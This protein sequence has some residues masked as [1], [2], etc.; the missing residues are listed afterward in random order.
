MKKQRPSGVFPVDIEYELKQSYLDYAMS[1]IIGRALPDVRDGLKPVHR[2]ILFAMK[3]LGN[4]SDKAYKKSARIV[5]DVIGK[6]HPHGD[7]AVYDAIVRMAQEFSLRYMLIDGQGNFGSVDGDSPAAMRYTEIRMSRIAH[8]LMSDVD[9]ETVD[10]STNYDETEL[11]PN[12]L[13]ARIPNLL[14]NGSSGIAVGMATNIPPHNLAEVVDGTIALIE[15]PNLDIEDLMKYIPGPDFPTGAYIDSSSNITEAYKTGRGKINVFARTKVEADKK[16]GREQ[17]I[18]TEIP[19]Q[20]NKARLIERIAELARDKKVR[21]I[22]ELRDESDKDGMRIVVDIKRGESSEVLLNNLYVQTQMHGSFGVNMVALVNNQPKLLNLKEIIERFISHRRSVVIR[23]TAFELRKAKEQAHILEGL[24]IALSN[25]DLILD[26]IQSSETSSKARETLLSYTWIKG[27]SLKQITEEVDQDL[28]RINRSNEKDYSLSKSQVNAI[29]ELRL[30]YLTR[31]EQNKIIE[32]FKSLILIIKNLVSILK[33]NKRLLEVVCTELQEVKEKFGDDRR[34]KIIS[35][36]LKLDH[37]DLINLEVKVVTLSYDGYVKSQPLTD[38]N[39]QRRGGRGKS[40]AQ[41]KAED[42][43]YKLQIASTHDTM[44]CFSSSGKIY[45]IKVYEFPQAGRTAKGKPINNL[46]PL[47]KG[48]RVTAMLAISKYDQGCN[49]FM[50]TKHAKVKKVDLT[51]FSRPRKGGICA[52]NLNE[53][54]ELLHVHLTNESQEIMMF[55]DAGKAIRFNESDVRVM[56]RTAR[57]VQGMRIEKNQRI[58]DVIVTE[59]D[60][61]IVLT[62]TE[63]GYGKRT[64]VSAYRKTARCS[65]GVISISTSDRNGLVV[66]AGLVKEN[67]D[68]IL[69]TDQGILIRMPVSEV[70]KTR[71]SAQGVKLIN[72]R[73][74]DKLVSVQVVDEEVIG[75]ISH[76][77]RFN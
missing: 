67:T 68:A 15:N 3:E 22:A 21:G 26:I 45:W 70:R 17:I 63:N 36:I 52:L 57:G 19:Y 48:E 6:Y 39:A 2:R 56:G 14:I 38:Y 32:N 16:T 34:S 7:T 25:A 72:L 31:L 66:A 28:Y 51:A 33:N 64:P 60:K 75:G 40:S 24:S 62:A 29:L 73:E 41:M 69:M 37:K 42:F 47:E 55:S 18:I 44:L 76:K 54:D 43:V 10:F 61:G 74:D 23:R 71:R 27:E 49:V 58:V 20:V 12:V 59:P 5:G 9:K 53:G 65:Q 35:S 46:L 4:T 30:H 11:L 8:A 1:V 77:S 13:P 50:A